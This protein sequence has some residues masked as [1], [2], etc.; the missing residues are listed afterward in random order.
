V[1][2]RLQQ[3]DHALCVCVRAC[4]VR[5]CV[6]ARQVSCPGVCARVC[7][8][9]CMADTALLATCAHASGPVSPPPLPSLPRSHRRQAACSL[10]IALV[11]GS[12]DWRTGCS[13]AHPSSVL[14]KSQDLR[15][16]L[17][18]PWLPHTLHTRRPRVVRAGKQDIAVAKAV[19]E[20]G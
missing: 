17:C 3:R 11:S 20:G 14:W 5:V 19:Q 18:S 7:A 2:A 6:C 1:K 16:L 9:V 8:C 13:D 15:P 4:V 12:S 10:T